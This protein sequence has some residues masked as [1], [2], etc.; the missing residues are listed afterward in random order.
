LIIYPINVAISHSILSGISEAI[1]LKLDK[2]EV[3]GKRYLWLVCTVNNLIFRERW[4]CLG[5]S[6]S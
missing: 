5:I 6:K 2:T 4:K 1:N 3:L